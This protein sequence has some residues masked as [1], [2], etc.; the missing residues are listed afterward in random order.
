MFPLISPEAQ[1]MLAICAFYAYDACVPM[2]EGAG[3]VRRPRRTCWRGMLAT[4]GF[5]V[6][7]AYLA[8]PAL[9]SPHQPVYQLRWQTDQVGLPGDAAAVRRLQAHADSFR[10][11]VL[12][13]YGLG[14]SLFLLLPSAL[15][16]WPG[17]AVQLA[18]AGMIYFFAA[19]TAVWTW[20]HGD[21]GHSPRPVARSV[22][23]QALAC[24]P[25]A[26]N[27]VRKLAAAYAPGMDLLQAAHRLLDPPAW[28]ALA[29][30]AQAA[31][32]ADIETAQAESPAATARSQRLS[33]ALRQ[34]QAHMPEAPGKETP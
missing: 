7:W 27:S 13:L 20:R 4:Q 8:W 23:I 5:E 25:F 10:H 32:E 21:K 34:L 9:L 30:R 29:Q 16:V 11:F 24:P 18:A 14:A 19:W 3:L 1:V 26:L 31:I 28:H 22:A 33:S 15:F 6:R 17:E 2:A 12:P